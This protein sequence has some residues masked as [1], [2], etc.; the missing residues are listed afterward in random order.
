MIEAIAGL[1]M[2]ALAGVA[3]IFKTQRDAARQ[4]AEEK[5]KEADQA[6]TIAEVKQNQTEE[7]IRS[8][9][10]KEKIDEKTDEIVK[11]PD[12]GFFE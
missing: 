9:E 4:D 11:R 10:K 6:K 2:A 7:L 12:R 1:F 5:R 8:A 3:Y